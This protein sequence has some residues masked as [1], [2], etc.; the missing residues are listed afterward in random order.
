MYTENEDN[1]ICLYIKWIWLSNYSSIRTPIWRT[2]MVLSLACAFE[3]FTF[4]SCFVLSLFILLTTVDYSWGNCI[5]SNVS[6]PVHIKLYAVHWHDTVKHA[7]LC[8]L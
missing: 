3:R 6:A 2:C 8:C 4:N 1:T 7:D 5:F